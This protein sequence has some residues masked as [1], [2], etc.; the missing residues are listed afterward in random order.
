MYTEGCAC[1]KFTSTVTD[2]WPIP[3]VCDLS[4]LVHKKYETVL[5][6]LAIIYSLHLTLTCIYINSWK[7]EAMLVCCS[8]ILSSHH[9]I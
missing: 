3:G 6:H 4:V 5:G 9:L 7:Y 2:G 1:D 8:N